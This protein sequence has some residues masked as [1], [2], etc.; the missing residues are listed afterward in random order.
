MPW[1]LTLSGLRPTG[2]NVAGEAVN[3]RVGAVK[4]ISHALATYERSLATALSSARSETQKAAAT[5]QLAVAES[6]RRLRASERS[7]Q[8]AVAELARC[9]EGCEGLAHELARARAAEQ[10]ARQHLELTRRAEAKFQRAATDLL[11]TMR[12]IEASAAE[13]APA[14]RRSVLEYAEILTDYLKRPGTP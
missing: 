1:P 3:A 8:E 4:E 11:S 2:S 5:F 6:H 10:A 14:G 9:R 13:H 7:T 12:T